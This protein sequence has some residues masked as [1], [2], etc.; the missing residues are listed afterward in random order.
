MSKQSFFSIIIVTFNAEKLIERTIN[1]VLSQTCNDFEI[2]IKDGCSDDATIKKIPHDRRIHTII[3]PDTSLY[4]AMNQ[5]VYESK[6]NY[7]IFMNSGDIFASNTVLES[8]KEKIQGCQ[9]TLVYGNYSRNRILHYQP[10]KLNS[11]YLY[12]TPLCHQSVFFNTEILQSGELYNTSYKILADYDLTLRLIKR[13]SIL[14]VNETICDYLGGG[15]SESTQGILI[16][17]TERKRIIEDR[18]TRKEKILNEIKLQMT[19]PVIRKTITR[20]NT[21]EFVKKLYQ[22]IVNKVNGQGKNIEG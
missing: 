3:K 11:F 22:M 4:D 1:S 14:H 9:Y 7:C 21:P 2:I 15:L 10:Q 8:V 16:K 13:G 5:A 19:F 17:K 12:R 20:G 6:G 18:F